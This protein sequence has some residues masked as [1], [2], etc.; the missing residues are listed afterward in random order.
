MPGRVMAPR[1]VSA[2]PPP[3]L[4]VLE[5]S[6]LLGRKGG[7]GFYQYQGEKQGDVNPRSTALGHHPHQPPG[8]PADEIRERSVLAI[9]RGVPGVE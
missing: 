3:P 6:L 7:L 1:S 5:A 8:L 9:E 2:C 4:L